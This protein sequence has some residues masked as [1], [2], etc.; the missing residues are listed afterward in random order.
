[1]VRSIST[2]LATVG[3]IFA[4]SAQ[5]GTVFENQF[6]EW[7]VYNKAWLGVCPMEHVPTADRSVSYY[8]THCWAVAGTLLANE[9]NFPVYSFRIYRDRTDGSMEISFTHAPLEAT[10][11]L[12]Q[13]RPLV[14]KVDN[15][16]GFTLDFA[17]DL[18]TRH[19]TVNVYY[20]KNRETT[21]AL[22]NAMRAGANL[23]VTVPLLRD[24]EATE[25][26]ASIWLYGIR[27][28]ER[29]MRAYA[30]GQP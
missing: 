5:S 30:N 26:T 28:S 17:N 18:E 29:F 2:A 19:N 22:V 15:G 14:L 10:D 23:A 12:D 11:R 13:S 21:D 1:M 9:F 16:P 25:D 3:L 24:G 7:R 4:S 8:S 20:P 27:A 6:G